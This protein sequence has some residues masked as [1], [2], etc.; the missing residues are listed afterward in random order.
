[1]TSCLADPRRSAS[2]VAALLCP[3]AGV[4]SVLWSVGLCAA[5][6]T[7]VVILVNG[8]HITGEV[9]ELQRGILSYSTDF[10][11]TISIEWQK[12]AQL[13]SGQ[14]LEVELMDGT[15]LYGRP[16]SLGDPGALALEDERTGG[17]RQVPLDQAVRIATLDQGRFRDRLD[18]YLDLG[19]S[20]AAADD[21][22]QLSVDA[23]LT[24]RD[25][26]RQW[27][28]DYTASHSKSEATPASSSQTLSIEQRRFLRERWFWSGA[29]S[30]QT[31]DQLGLDL[32]LLL[33]GGFGRYLIQTARQE[34]VAGVGLAV[35]RERF[36]DGQDQD[37]LEGVLLG[38]YD[39]F[40]FR[41]PEIDISTELKVYPSFTVSGR[42]RTDAHITVS[43]E[44]IKDFTYKLSFTHA[45]DS[46]P[47]SVDAP[48][49][50]WSL[51]TSLGYEF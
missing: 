25:E 31:N 5:P 47:Q 42:V 45:Y 20:A 1:M 48:K 9:K 6:K 28:F 49:S 43:Y 26:I 30:F 7:D 15:K 19:W 11:G 23:G 16:K 27:E 13:Q 51:F 8:D 34:L 29:G 40:K 10:M 14:V 38:S 39:L 37:S 36:S 12:V 22:S 2:T 33:G 18:G 4:L 24:Y 32:R 50:D 46:E 44:F 3:L 21:V 17:V 41:D 35:S